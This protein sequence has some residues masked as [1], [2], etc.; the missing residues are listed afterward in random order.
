MT[1]LA[2][3]YR[4]VPRPIT[5]LVL[6]ALNAKFNV[7]A[8]GIFR[9]ADGRILVLKH[10][11]RHAHPWALPGGYL[12]HGETAEAGI[13]RELREET[14]LVAEIERVFCVDDVDAWQREIVFLGRVNA[15]QPLLLNHEIAQ[16]GFF[17]ADQLPADMLPRHAGLVA[18]CAAQIL[19]EH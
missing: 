18:R 7:G 10:V 12:Q 1:I 14:G 6:W 15:N 2:T 16:A 9:S 4:L 13:V 19:A 5:R 11:Y 8:V 17:A 3:I